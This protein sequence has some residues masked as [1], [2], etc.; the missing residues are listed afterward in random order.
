MNRPENEKQIPSHQAAATA[1]F[2]FGQSVLDEMTAEMP[3]ARIQLNSDMGT[4]LPIQMSG[5]RYVL[6]DEIARGGMGAV[7]R[8]RDNDLGR[9]LAIKILLDRHLDRPDMLRR[10]VEEAQIGGQLQHPGVVPVHEIGQLDDQ[11]LFFSMKLVEGETL[12]ALLAKR[13]DPGEERQRFVKIFEQIS[14]TLSYAHSRDV[15]H[16]DLKPAN[17][18]V[19]AFGEVQVMDW[20][21]AKVLGAN[22]PVDDEPIAATPD[23]ESN[24]SSGPVR[25]AR[26]D[27]STAEGI[28]SQTHFGSV[29]GTPSYMPME[30]ALGEIEDVDKRS[31]VFGLGALL[32]VILTGR[33]P[34]RGATPT[35]TLNMAQG[36]NI[37][38]A[39]ALL[40]ESGADAELVDLAK[41][42]LAKQAD[43]RP[44][45]ATAVTAEITAH[46]ASVE[47]RLRQA[48][49]DR[50]EARTKAAEERKRRRV[51]MAL[52]ASVVAIVGIGGG[53]TA[54]IQRQ[55]TQLANQRTETIRTDAARQLKEAE[56][57]K[58]RS[59][60]VRDALGEAH[61]LR[62]RALEAS[63]DDLLPWTKALE[64]ARRAETLTAEGNVDEELQ[65]LARDARQQL[66]RDLGDR[67]LIQQLEVAWQ[68][69]AEYLATQ[70]MEGLAVGQK[71]VLLAT[72][73]TLPY[74]EQAFSKWGLEVLKAT[75][76]ESA[77][78]IAECSPEV[79]N[80]VVV[81]LDRM[82]ELMTLDGDDG[83]TKWLESVVAIVDDDEWRKG[84]REELDAQDVVALAKRA[85]EADLTTQ[86]TM[87]WVRC[88]LALQRGEDERG[89]FQLLQRLDRQQPGDYWVNFSLAISLANHRPPR[90]A[91]SLRHATAAAAL[92]PQNGVAQF[93]VARLIRETYRT[94]LAPG[95][96]VQLA[97]LAY[98]HAELATTYEPQN[99]VC[100]NLLAIIQD[101][102]GRR[103]EAIETLITASE[104]APTDAQAFH[105][106][107]S[108]LVDRGR[109]DE[110]EGYL[111]KAMELEPDNFAPHVN[112]GN[113]L[114]SRNEIE[115]GI[116]EYELAAELYP[117]SAMPDNNRG[118]ALMI[119]KR[120]DEA[121]A[122][123]RKAIEVEPYHVNAQYNLGLVLSLTGDDEGALKAY[124]KVTDLVDNNPDVFDSIA[125]SH[126]HL[127]N[128][129]KA[130]LAW[131]KSIE[132]KPD[133]PHAYY[134]LAVAYARQGRLPEA[135]E[136]W[137]MAARFAPTHARL[138]ANMGM[139]WQDLNRLDRAIPCFQEAVRLAPE[140]PRVRTD[141]AT[142]LYQQGDL[143][144]CIAQLREAIKFA[145]D[146]SRV[147]RLLDEGLLIKEARR[148][149]P[150]IL[151]G[152]AKFESNDLRLKASE[153]CA[154][155]EHFAAAASLCRDAFAVDSEIAND[156]ESQFR[157]DA[158]CWA[159]LAGT[160][161]DDLVENSKQRDDWRAQSLKWLQEDLKILESMAKTGSDAQREEAREQLD[162]WLNDSNLVS[163]RSRN[164]LGFLP[165]EE[166][167]RWDE[168]WDNV[169]S[170]PVEE[171]MP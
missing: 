118:I 63:I 17:I 93:G 100:L 40:D 92:R 27:G 156:T 69:D 161:S 149:M 48:E 61:A 15:I 52:A 76:E 166:R 73:Q 146:D 158:A 145:P 72:P 84:F 68:L 154:D 171:K 34:Y 143:D 107:G 5:K 38:P 71:V 134:N 155:L 125:V 169:R 167:R 9:D 99:P 10:F 139:A 103:D 18:M 136:Q 47:N 105:N 133:N 91:E 112:L 164:R 55:Q 144:E 148:M 163:V 157:Y 62:N 87:I 31:D 16:R 122:A 78:K 130:L 89:A 74:Y 67:R 26:S 140:D 45:D 95:Q 77:S 104:M 152:T 43:D 138:H 83:A 135:I 101:D 113:L 24:I 121:I 108:L 124:G 86:P 1:T 128:L 21:L 56:Q 44:R 97:E 147:K 42:C 58:D 153:E 35:E 53:A 60:R 115:T 94:G 8:G 170:L 36:G 165:E 98:E 59:Q 141:L 85:A 160:G 13:A 110:A 114:V 131:Q 65:L 126:D 75:E 14:Q 142:A 151:A 127:G 123:F 66:D 22:R 102:L 70:G 4:E 120:N 23:G 30:Q 6:Y 162:G 33:P 25:T 150:E 116:E 57:R 29:I 168:F 80:R 119:L 159:A 117:Y 37:E 54:L 64:A 109:F 106:I 88:A 51:T 32:C 39:F 90:L 2:G 41:R 46:L 20:G 79:K 28:G 49:L 19:G 132:L 129:E 11:R 137:E 12:D 82:R 3:A 111:R 50:L 7:H 81:A 96:R